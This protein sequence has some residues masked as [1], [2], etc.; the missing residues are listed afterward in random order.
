MSRSWRLFLEDIIDAATKIERRVKGKS[1]EEFVA[2][3]VL[4]DS[5]IRNLEI[6]GEAAKGIPDSVRE[7]LPEIEW[8]RIAGLRDIL[9]HAYFA[10]DDTI[11]WEIVSE[12]VPALLLRATRL[13]RETIDD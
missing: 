7:R 3:D 8:R 10:I 11:V 4:Y 12:K 6:I 2:D 9:S 1:F 5:V 13:K